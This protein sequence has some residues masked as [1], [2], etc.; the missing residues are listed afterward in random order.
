MASRRWRLK[1]VS[2]AVGLSIAWVAA[3]LLCASHGAP[4]LSASSASDSE[5]SARVWAEGDDVSTTW[6]SMQ[7]VTTVVGP[8]Y[9]VW[10]I[11]QHGVTVTFNQEAV[12]ATSWFT[13]TPRTQTE[14]P[15]GYTSTPYVFDLNGTYRAT[16][17][18]VSLGNA[19][20]QIEVQYDPSE[21]DRIDPRTLQFFHRGKTEWFPQGGDVD[22]LAETISLKTERTQ[23]FAVG[24]EPPKRYLYL[25]IVIRE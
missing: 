10:P 15:I 4:A 7:P 25:S 13:F 6:T 8:A 23:S 14:L 1:K 9:F 11:T 5:P 17:K 18:P 16:G 22:L 2:C 21:L 3:L 19:G 20:I 24:G 12:G